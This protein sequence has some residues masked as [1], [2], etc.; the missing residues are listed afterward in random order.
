MRYEEVHTEIA[1]L[2]Q[3]KNRAYIGEDQK[4]QLRNFREASKKLNVSL[5]KILLSKILEKT[6]RICSQLREGKDGGDEK[7][8]S[9]AE[10]LANYSIFLAMALHEES[11]VA[12]QIK[13]P[14]INMF[15]TWTEAPYDN[16]PFSYPAS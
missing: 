12:V 10:D 11:G 5:S 13:L 7:I 6:N 8:F 3:K 1:E 14:D 15:K 2:F 9:D 16:N 4:D